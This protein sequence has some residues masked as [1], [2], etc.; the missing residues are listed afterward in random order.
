M[1]DNQDVLNKVALFEEM[2]NKKSFTFFD[3]DILKLL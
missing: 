2:I 3:V 1:D